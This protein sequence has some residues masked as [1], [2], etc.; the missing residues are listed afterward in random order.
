LE[1]KQLQQTVV[2]TGFGT[3]AVTEV[4][5]GKSWKVAVYDGRG[6][7]PAEFTLGRDVA[8][9]L[10]QALSEVLVTVPPTPDNAGGRR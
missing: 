8:A 7:L 10:I 9:G 2:N 6:G 5:P 3:V 1:K 4:F